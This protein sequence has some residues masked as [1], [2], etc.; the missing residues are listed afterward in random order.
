MVAATNRPA[1]LDQALTRPGRFD[2][3]IQLP[4]PNVDGRID[5]LKVHLRGV[6]V[7][8]DLDMR[9]VARATAGFTGADIM[10]LVNQAASISVRQNRREVDEMDF[11]DALEEIHNE[12]QH[13]RTGGYKY[14][15]DVVT[16][17]MKQS[18]AIY[19]SAKAIIG[20]ITPFFDEIFRVNVCPNG[21]P[22][23]STF[24]VPREDRLESRLITKG[25]LVI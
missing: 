22:T 9:R 10:N 24:F 14:E 8:D 17:L 11:F 25:S 18:I 4:L 23:G 20:Y 21:Q 5:I 12:R 7:S 6:M 15:A 16:P 1:V 3:I 13:R 19:E 2:R